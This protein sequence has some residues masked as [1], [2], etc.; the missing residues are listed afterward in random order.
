MGNPV[1]AAGIAIMVL[2]LIVYFGIFNRIGPV[3]TE[4]DM[5]RLSF[6]FFAVG[7][8]TILTQSTPT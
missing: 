3:T 2:G 1:I 4:R 7:F 8:I 5:R 6:V